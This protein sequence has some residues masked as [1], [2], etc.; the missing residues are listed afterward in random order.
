MFAVS[1]ADCREV[2]FCRQIHSTSWC[3]ERCRPRCK[4]DFD[5]WTTQFWNR[6]VYSFIVD[7]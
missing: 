3:C 7:M 2:L 4:R 1:C 6:S 5:I